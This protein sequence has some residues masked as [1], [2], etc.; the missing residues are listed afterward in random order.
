V[1]AEEQGTAGFSEIWHKP[2][3]RRTIMMMVFN[4]FQTIGYVFGNYDEPGYLE[5][6]FSDLERN[7]YEHLS[8]WSKDS[9]I[10]R[11]EFENGP[12]RDQVEATVQKKLADRDAALKKVDDEIKRIQQGNAAT[13][14][15]ASS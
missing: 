6:D 5:T 14:K 2:Y 12:L 3:R 11:L 1:V 10:K 7:D 9:F 13:E 15:S 8:Y 4:I